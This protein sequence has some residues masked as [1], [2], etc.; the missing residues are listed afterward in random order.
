[1]RCDDVIRILAAPNEG[2]NSAAVA[3]HLKKCPACA[4]WSARMS[5]FD[6]LWDATRPV[7]PS[8]EQWDA[9]WARLERSID[10]T[11]DHDRDLAE[12]VRPTQTPHSPI[13]ET[14]SSEPDDQPV[15]LPFG[16]QKMIG[17]DPSPTTGSHWTARRIAAAAGILLL[18]G[19]ARFGISSHHDAST[20]PPPRL[21]TSNV[22]ATQA[23]PPAFSMSSVE[24]GE[25]ELVV[26][27]T[28]GDMVRGDDAQPRIARFEPDDAVDSWYVMFNAI[29]S[30]ANPVL[31][32][33]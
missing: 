25:G 2:E 11:L 4:E 8:A 24:I 16:G 5:S 15:L 32:V 7:E 29:E 28:G 30:M 18:L 9:V 12:P 22:A 1:M 31:A 3:E 13:R 19:L 21:A 17:G 26:I 14:F 33:R 20:S 6:R 23:D 10:P 27:R